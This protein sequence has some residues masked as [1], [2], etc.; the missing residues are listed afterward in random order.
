[1]SMPGWSDMRP[2]FRCITI[3]ILLLLAG[4]PVSVVGS[5]IGGLSGLSGLSGLVGGGVFPPS[6]ANR[7]HGAADASHQPRISISPGKLTRGAY[8]FAPDS[9]VRYLRSAG[10]EIA[11]FL[12]ARGLHR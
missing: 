8:T 9:R 11:R 7:Y 12:R 1:M 5:G 10:R 3:L 2:I 4:L 6:G